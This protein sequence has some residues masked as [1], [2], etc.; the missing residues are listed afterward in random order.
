MLKKVGARKWRM[1]YQP[2][3]VSKNEI[4]IKEK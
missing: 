1:Y 2:I 4:V 3:I